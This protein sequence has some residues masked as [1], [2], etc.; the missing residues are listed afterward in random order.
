MA[1]TSAATVLGWVLKR[2]SSLPR[3]RCCS[4]STSSSLQFN[5]TFAPP[6][7][8]PKQSNDSDEDSGG[9]Q[10]AFIPWIVRGEDGKLKLLTEPPERLVHAHA[11]SETAKKKKK[12]TTTVKSAPRKTDNEIFRESIESPDRLSKVLAAAGGT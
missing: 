9:F 10:Q 6:K 7:P 3:I 8:K 12:P 1:A 11:L 4:S 5:I 2:P